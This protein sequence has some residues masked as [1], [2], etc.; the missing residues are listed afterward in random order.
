[1]LEVA[2]K[3]R[4]K[5]LICKVGA[6]WSCQHIQADQME[7][8]TDAETASEHVRSGITENGTVFNGEDGPGVTLGAPVET[9]GG[10]HH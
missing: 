2:S 6:G 7:R 1:M 8:P 10:L 4:L 9:V 3:A 5:L